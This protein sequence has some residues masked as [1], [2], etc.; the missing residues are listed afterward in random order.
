MTARCKRAICSSSGRIENRPLRSHLFGHLYPGALSVCD[1]GL[2]F[3]RED[4]LNYRILEGGS[5]LRLAG[6]VEELL[7]AG[8]AP[9]LEG[10][11]HS[12]MPVEVGLLL[13]DQF[14]EVYSAKVELRA[15]HRIGGKRVDLRNQIPRYSNGKN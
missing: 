10:Y 9:L 12:V 11:V 15:D 3:D 8:A 7:I 6:P 14:D 4:V 5:T 1:K 2:E 13:A